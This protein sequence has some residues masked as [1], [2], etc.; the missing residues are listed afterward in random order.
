MIS[1]CHLHYVQVFKARQDTEITSFPVGTL[2]TAF[3]RG[4]EE[5]EGFKGRWRRS[6]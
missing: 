5:G 3:Y 1:V 4:A 2:G 6:Q